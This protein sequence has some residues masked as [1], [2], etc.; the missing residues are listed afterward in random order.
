MFIFIITTITIS[1]TII[2]IIISI[3]IISSSG[4]HVLRKREDG[5]YLQSAALTTELR[6]HA[7]GEDEGWNEIV[8]VALSLSLYICICV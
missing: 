3:I 7:T 6:T 1:I 2:I 5:G 8:Q 4:R